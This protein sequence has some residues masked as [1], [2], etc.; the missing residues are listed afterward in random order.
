MAISQ[1]EVKSSGTLG[2]LVV[3]FHGYTNRPKDMDS[4]EGLI[5]AK[6]RDT[7]VCKPEMP[8]T[9][10]STVDPR[11][12][13][14]GLLT[15]I[16][17][18]WHDHGK[19]D[20]IILIGHSVGALLARKVYVAACGPTEDAP[21]SDVLNIREPQPWAAHVK[22]IVLLAGMNRGWEISY[23]FSAKK[24]IIWT[25]GVWI[26]NVIELVAR[27][28]PL[29]LHMRRGAR[30]ITQLRLQWLAM[31]KHA[32]DRGTGG[33]LTVQLLGSTDDAVSPE[34][35]LDLITGRDFIYL[36]V[37]KT[38]HNDIIHVDATCI[39]DKESRSGIL[40]DAITLPPDKLT[41]RAV[42]V[43]DQPLPKE[44]RQVDEVIFVVHGIRDVGY[45]T[46]KIARRVIARAR[47]IDKDNKSSE[48]LRTRVFAMETASYGYFPMAPF[49]FAA[50]RRQ[51][52]EWLMNQ[53][54]EAMANYPK[55]EFS[56]IAHSNGTY[57][58]AKALEEY[59]ACRF[60]RIVFAGSVVRQSFQWN[61]YIASR[62]V[63]AV[64]NYVATG[65]WVVAFFPKLFEFFR[66]QDLGSAGFD[67]FTGHNQAS[68][69]QV[70]YVKGGHGAALTEEHWDAI[71]DFIVNPLQG[72]NPLPQPLPQPEGPP[73]E[74]FPQSRWMKIV[75]QL[76][77][78]VWGILLAILTGIGVIIWRILPNNIIR[79]AALLLY[80]KVIWEI[81][82]R[83]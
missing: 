55:A 3:L 20:D 27:R 28:P 68:L 7:I 16:N 42:E 66:I 75:S 32:K 45:W 71:A 58:V 15:H 24:A 52:V 29:M 48:K 38:G 35:N 77:P 43:S 47:K 73:P 76:P 23:H 25:I 50:R 69:W 9:R 78:L 22:R 40:A 64:L 83:V 10:W 8:L 63:Q 39:E 33:A 30:F 34:D 37:P 18:E 14:L 11:E 57:L 26:G 67:G 51:K 80:V 12:V 1:P 5:K 6:L 53:Y 74:G 79:T 46:Q 19:P 36:D 54:A 56:C 70:K 41:E 2:P 82:T 21:F 13:V 44:D 59:A 61:Q 17:K 72:S 4:I 49:L 31:K 62:R 81:L 65:D 60:K